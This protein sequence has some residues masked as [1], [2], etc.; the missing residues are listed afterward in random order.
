MPDG[1][2]TKEATATQAEQVNRSGSK[3]AIIGVGV[4]G[5]MLAVTFLEQQLVKPEHL[6]LYH[7][8]P[9]Q[10]ENLCA[11]WPGLVPAAS[12][13]LAVE[14]ADI[15]IVAVQP[16]KMPAVLKEI[17]PVMAPAARLWLTTSHLPDKLVRLFW[18]GRA[19]TCLPTVAGRYGKGTV[20]AHAV[21]GTGAVQAES[22][23][24][25]SPTKARPEAPV[26]T[27]DSEVATAELV[28]GASSPEVPA[29][30]TCA[31]LAATEADLALH[32]H[33]KDEFAYYFSFLCRRLLWVEDGGFAV[34]NNITGCAPA[35]VCALIQ[36]V[37]EA[38][39]QHEPDFDRA[40][41]IEVA[42][43][44]FK[45]TAVLLEQEALPPADLIGRVGSPGGITYTAMAALDEAMPAVWQDLI[46]RSTDR[47]SRADRETAAAAIEIFNKKG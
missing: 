3:I 6:K 2:L 26:E 8:H 12:A 24:A 25:D 45:S 31:P 44:A 28:A 35:F 23:G 34:L 5:S 27:D 18:P 47:H 17:C 16:A 19:V 41:L 10:L 40:D 46:Q 32:P 22:A 36:S 20:L 11:A 33:L 4:I 9:D 15:V 1:V 13:E 7:R 30:S 21:Y 42:A 29:G 37:A 38:V 39:A 43:E 14:E